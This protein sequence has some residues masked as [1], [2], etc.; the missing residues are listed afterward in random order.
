MPSEYEISCL[1]QTEFRFRIIEDEGEKSHVFVKTLRANY[2][3]C[4]VALPSSAYHFKD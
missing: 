4:L 1:G 3:S 2:N